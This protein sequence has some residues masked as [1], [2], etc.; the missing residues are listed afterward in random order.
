MPER[1]GRICVWSSTDT[2]ATSAGNA[3]GNYPL[4]KAGIFLIFG[5]LDGRD[6]LYPA[7]IQICPLVEVAKS[8]F[9]IVYYGQK[10]Q[11]LIKIISVKL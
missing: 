8:L 7:I 6:F 1:T 5:I 4:D 9:V 11:R 2:E 10:T 3:V